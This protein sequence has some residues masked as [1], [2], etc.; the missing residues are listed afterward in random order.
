MIVR[1]RSKNSKKL[2]RQLPSKLAFGDNNQ[3]MFLQ[4]NS[5]R[6]QGAENPH[7]PGRIL[8]ISFWR[9]ISDSDCIASQVQNNRGFPEQIEAEIYGRSIV[10]MMR[11]VLYSS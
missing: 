8:L 4:G 9:P 2:N 6:T 7:P 1:G 3:S 5:Y 11:I 10:Y